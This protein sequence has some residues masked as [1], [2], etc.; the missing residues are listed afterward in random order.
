[1]L[2]IITSFHCD[3]YSQAEKRSSLSSDFRES[4]RLITSSCEEIENTGDY[5]DNYFLFLD[6]IMSQ[7]ESAPAP[8]VKVPKFVIPDLIGV[9]PKILISMYNASYLRV[10][11]NIRRILFRPISF[12]TFSQGGYKVSA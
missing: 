1:M 9:Q 4:R 11:I 10:W 2:E 12:S 3:V 8:S 7:A 6:R 5:I